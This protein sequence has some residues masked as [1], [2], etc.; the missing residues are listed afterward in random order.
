MNPVKLVNECENKTEAQKMLLSEAYDPKDPELVNG[1]FFANKI[2]TEL[3][4]CKDWSKIEQRKQ[5][6]KDLLGTYNDAN[7]ESPFLCTY[8]TNVHFGE[9][10]NVDAD[11]IFLDSNKIKIGSNTKIG[12]NVQLYTSEYSTDPNDRLYQKANATAKP[13]SIGKDCWIG[14]SS[15]VLPGVTI[16]DGVTVSAGSVVTKDV[17]CYHVVAGNPAKIIKKLPNT[18]LARV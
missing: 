2:L 16:G 7:I 8:G 3:N 18:C 15:V 11:C 10:C 12:P 17:P 5:L 9:R 14:G 1:R 4:C 6:L 13:I